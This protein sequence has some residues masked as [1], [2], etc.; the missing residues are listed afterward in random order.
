MN[1]DPR[2]LL[3]R[4]RIRLRSVQPTTAPSRHTTLWRTTV[5]RPLSTVG[6]VPCLPHG[7]TRGTVAHPC[8]ARPWSTMTRPPLPTTMGNPSTLSPRGTPVLPCPHNRLPMIPMRITIAC[9]R[10]R[11]RRPPHRL[12]RNAPNCS[13]NPL[14]QM[15]LQMA[16]GGRLST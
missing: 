9:P 4:T 10:L 12:S 3:Q 11:S 15:P 14:V 7:S 13:G 1:M 5:L 16:V 6:N 2:C 8:T